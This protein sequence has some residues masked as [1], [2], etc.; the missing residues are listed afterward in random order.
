MIPNG[1]IAIRKYRSDIDK[2]FVFSTLLKNYKHSSYFAKRIKPVIFFAGHHD[3]VAYLVEKPNVDTFIAHPKDDTETI[4]GY[5]TC[6]RRAEEALPIVHFVFVKD[7]FRN[8]GIAR[9]LF[10]HAKINPNEMRFT[11]W[12]YPVDDLIRKWPEMIY[13]PYKL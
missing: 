6:E 8:M 5:L 1:S 12:T 9:A 3:V 10:E 13:D 7:A 4:L 2:P 11:H